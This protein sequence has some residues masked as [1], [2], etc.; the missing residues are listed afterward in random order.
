[1]SLIPNAIEVPLPGRE[2]NRVSIVDRYVCTV[3]N[4]VCAIKNYVCSEKNYVFRNSFRVRI[5]KV[6][7][8]SR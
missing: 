4:C 7:G 2:M 3:K 1:M 8:Y 5:L 6:R